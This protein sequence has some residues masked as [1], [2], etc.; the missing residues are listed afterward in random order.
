[1]SRIRDRLNEAAEENEAAAADPRFGLAP[2]EGWHRGIPGLSIERDPAKRRP[3]SAPQYTPEWLPE[4]E[5]DYQ[6]PKR[7]RGTP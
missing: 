6:P 7:K 3:P 1:M 4:D 2:P 5:D